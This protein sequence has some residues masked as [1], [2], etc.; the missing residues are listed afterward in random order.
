MLNDK[1]LRDEIIRMRRAVRARQ[2]GLGDDIV[3][4]GPDDIDSASQGRPTTEQR[5]LAAARRP[6]WERESDPLRDRAERC[7]GCGGNVYRWPC[8]ACSMTARR[9][10]S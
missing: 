4:E 10:R 5:D 8:L 2:L 6:R 7:P 1:Q 9:V 3:E